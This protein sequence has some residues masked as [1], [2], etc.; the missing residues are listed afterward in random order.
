MRA[1]RDRASTAHLQS[2][3]T[4]LYAY[5]DSGPPP[6]IANYTTVV[7]IHGYVWHGGNFRKLIPLAHQ[8][9]ARVVAVNRHGYPGSAPFNNVDLSLL[10]SL[11]TSPPTPNNAET[12]LAFMRDRT[13]EIHDYLTRFITSEHTPLAGGIILVGWSFGTVWMN[14]LLANIDYCPPREVDLR[15]Y[16][17]R[18]VY[19]DGSYV[20]LGQ[21]PPPV[22]YPSEPS[23]AYDA[24]LSGYHAH[25]DIWSR[26][27]SALSFG[28]ALADPS[29]TTTRM[30]SE[31]LEESTYPPAGGPGGCDRLLTQACMKLG[32]YQTLHRRAFYL[33][34]DGHV[35]NKWHDV[36]VRVV[37]CDHTEWEMP[38]GAY[39]LYKELQ[40][41]RE[42]GLPVRDAVF[43]RLRGANHFAHW[44]MPE[45]VLAAFLELSN[46]D[47]YCTQ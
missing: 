23:D 37:W 8:H 9:R 12:M 11:V 3:D 36:E 20:G 14:A 2:S 21:P 29:P 25:G 22:A 1:T 10:E 13:Q 19:Y 46:V 35:G 45:H 34:D 4:A 39:S 7:I 17:K 16:F 6:G 41:S 42:A 5:L 43:V 15:S 18:I 40:E 26:G 24:W 38:W 30:S 47:E 44:D 32:T 31:E 28:P 27:A 33:D